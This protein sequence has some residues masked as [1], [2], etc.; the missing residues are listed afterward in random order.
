MRKKRVAENT[1]VPVKKHLLFVHGTTAGIGRI[2]VAG[3]MQG[4]CAATAAG[5]R[6]IGAASATIVRL[7]DASP[8]KVFSPQ[9]SQGT[10]PDTP[11][12]LLLAEKGARRDPALQV[13]PSLLQ[14]AGHPNPFQPRSAMLRR[15][16][17]PD[18]PIL[19]IF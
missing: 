19:A 7:K 16:T 3:V 15:E 12:Q 10:L 9:G 14:V 2:N 6:E 17:A 8:G 11:L 1:A 18:R 4:P 5:H 13:M